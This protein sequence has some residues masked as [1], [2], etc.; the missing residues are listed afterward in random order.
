MFGAIGVYVFYVWYFVCFV[1]LYLQRCNLEDLVS[2]AFAS[3]SRPVSS[4]IYCN[5]ERGNSKHQCVKQLK[6]PTHRSKLCLQWYAIYRQFSVSNVEF[7]ALVLSHALVYSKSR[8][9]IKPLNF[10]GLY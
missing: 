6:Q 1:S 8:R 10:D 4:L 3:N 5:E 9:S 7:H 2:I